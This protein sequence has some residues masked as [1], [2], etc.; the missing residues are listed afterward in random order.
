MDTFCTL[1]LPR[2]QGG[3]LGGGRAWGDPKPSPQ[4]P[5][6][7]R[8]SHT[9]PHAQRQERTRLFGKATVRT[10]VRSRSAHGSPSALLRKLMLRFS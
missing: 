9:Q 8:L 4:P 7:P 6:R 2:N 3:L 5:P 10:R 1:L